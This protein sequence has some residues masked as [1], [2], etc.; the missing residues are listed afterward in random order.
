MI[1]HPATGIAVNSF[2]SLADDARRLRD[3]LNREHITIAP[4]S[5]LDDVITGAEGIASI[6]ADVM[7]DPAKTREYFAHTLGLA[8]LARALSDASRSEC[9]S[10][11]TRLL[12]ELADGNPFM[13]E[14][15]LSTMER[16]LAFELEIASIFLASRV[17]A[18]SRAEPDVRLYDAPSIWNIACKMIYSHDPRTLCNNIEKGILQSLLPGADYGIVFLGLSSRIDH[19]AYLPVVGQDQLASFTDLDQAVAFSKQRFA[20][21]KNQILA[22]RSTRFFHGKENVRFRGIA[23]LFH[24]VVGVAGVMTIVSHVGLF[25]RQDLYDEILIG[26]ERALIDAFHRTAQNLMIR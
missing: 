25:T 3:L 20:E 5:V 9:F 18:E 17:C 12:P 16:N 11:V 15:D 19:E 23:A 22:E 10:R 13:A 6:A 2:D 4:G 26:P 8:F 1:I 21:I 7:A 24:T 14:A